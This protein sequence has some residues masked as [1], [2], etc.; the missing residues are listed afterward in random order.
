MLQMRPATSADR[1]QVARMV[2]ARCAWLETRGLPSWRD[3]LDDL[4]AQCDNPGGDVWVLDD[5]AYGVVGQILVQDQ[6]PPWGWT[7][8]ERA[9]PALYLSGSITDPALRGEPGVRPGTLMAW[10]AVDRAAL[11]GVDWVRRHCHFEQVARYNQTQGFALVREQQRTHA[12]LYLMARR[13]ERL[14]LSEWIRSETHVR[15]GRE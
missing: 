8:A 7:D 2:R 1:G 13:A 4:V 6:G 3:A 15:P 11:L 10:W 5:D 9:E 12:R 14:D